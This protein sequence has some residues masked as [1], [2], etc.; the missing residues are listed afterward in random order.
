MDF[1]GGGESSNVSLWCGW[2]A[3]SGE[4]G[5]DA[6][7]EAFRL[8][9]AWDEARRVGVARERVPPSSEHA[10][11]QFGHLPSAFGPCNHWEVKKKMRV[12]QQRTKKDVH[13][14]GVP[15]KISS[16]NTVSDKARPRIQ[17]YQDT[18]YYAGLHDRFTH[19]IP[20]SRSTASFFRRLDVDVDNDRHEGRRRGTLGT[21]RPAAA[22]CST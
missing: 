3:A 22:H 19:Q 5:Y 10:F 14:Q 17:S 4:G 15:C 16:R 12:A 7:L 13:L 20:Q 2:R 6:G 9:G 1:A 8:F 18:Q 21:A 11:S